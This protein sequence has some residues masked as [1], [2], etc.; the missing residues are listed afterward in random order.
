MRQKH[1]FGGILSMA[2][3]F[4]MVL[5]GC[6]YNGPTADEIAD[7]VMERQELSYYSDQIKNLTSF[8][9]LTIGKDILAWGQT[10]A[11]YTLVVNTAERESF[12]IGGSFVWE[13]DGNADI[14]RSDFLITL[15]EKSNGK[16]ATFNFTIA[17]VVDTAKPIK[18]SLT[19][20]TSYENATVGVANLNEFFEK[21]LSYNTNNIANFT[22]TTNTPIT[23]WGQTTNA[24]YAITADIYDEETARIY[25]PNAA[26]VLYNN[27]NW[28]RALVEWK[29]PVLGEV[30]AEMDNSYPSFLGS[31]HIG[32]NYLDFSNYSGTCYD[33]S[34][35]ST[36]AKQ[37]KF[38][39]RITYNDQTISGTIT[40]NIKKLTKPPVQLEQEAEK[41]Q[42]ERLRDTF[43]SCFWI[44]AGSYHGSV[45][46]RFIDKGITAFGQTDVLYNIAVRGSQYYSE[47]NYVT[48]EYDYLGYVYLPS[49]YEYS[50]SVKQVIWTTKTA[51]AAVILEDDYYEY[52]LKVYTGKTGT[53]EFS[54]TYTNP[55]NKTVKGTVKVTVVK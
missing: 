4:V 42:L 52:C 19:V 23:G 20:T 41:E 12:Q 35:D 51:N 15:A 40:V 55:S 33:L 16:T 3:V 18:G 44:N 28:E 49:M 37:A 50:T 46:T 11:A 13:G 10:D 24:A 53:A 27:Y 25:S 39:F 26:P 31:T 45:I 43:N 8:G 21:V 6:E 54:F 1:L 17:N 48:N 14:K 38:E 2:L 47:W 22:L 7:I 36:I 32:G 30:A 29:P 34:T 9:K 5:T